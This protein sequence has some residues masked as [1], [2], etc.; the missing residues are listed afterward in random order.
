M[1]NKNSNSLESVLITGGMGVLGSYFDFGTKVDSQEMDITN[2]DAV[3]KVCAEVKP[4]VI[5]HC[6][7]LTDLPLCE[8]QP[9][10]AYLVNA[11]GTYHMALTAHKTGAKLIYVSTSD[12]FDGSATE[13][14]KEDD[15][16]NPQSVYGRSKYLGELA[17]KGVL[18]NYLIVRISWMFGGGPGKDNKF[19][20]KILGR[21]DV[22]EI[23]AV[24]DKRAS[25][26]WG[27]DVAQ[28][29]GKLIEKDARGV[30]H[31]SSGVATRFEMAQE[32]ASI[33]GWKTKVVPA[34]SSEFPS[35]YAIGEN[36]S[37]SPSPLMRPWQEALKEYIQTEWQ[38]S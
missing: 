34:S 5:V 1:S 26:S 19:V 28:A 14:Y 8:A 12:V 32:I 20:G 6:A 25:P 37:M 15:A 13:P 33:T 38:G 30:C 7:A 35:T 17:V 23:R 29:I 11:V 9:D 3:M 27:K 18:D 24:N 4:R 22:P 16:P 36:Q 21:G 2:L 10:K 31:L